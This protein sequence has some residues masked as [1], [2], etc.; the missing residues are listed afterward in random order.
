MRFALLLTTALAAILSG[1]AV[2][3]PAAAQTSRLGIVPND[4]PDPLGNSAPEARIVGGQA[5]KAGD[6]PWQVFFT[7]ATAEGRAMCGGSLISPTW[8]LTA[9]HCV[10]GKKDG[11]GI[12]VLSGTS[13][14]GAGDGMK[15][16]V[17]RVIAH[18][19]YK[20]VSTGNDIALLELETPAKAQTVRLAKGT[21]AAELERSGGVATVTGWGTTSEGG[22]VSEKLMEVQV[23]LVD[24]AACRQN[25]QQ[26]MKKELAI[27]AQQLCAGYDQGGKDS[28]QGDSG[29]P[30]VVP[31]GRGGWAQVGVVSWGAGCARQKLYGIYTRVS[32]YT[33]WIAAKTGIDIPATPAATPAA[34]AATAAAT[35]PTPPAQPPAVQPASAPA[36]STQTAST[37]A[38]AAPAPAAPVSAPTGPDRAL[39]IGIDQYKNPKANLQGSVTD[40]QNM[41]AFLERHWGYPRSAIKTLTDAQATRENILAAMDDWLVKGSKPGGRV[42]LYYSGHGYYQP[43]QDGD[44]G[45]GSDEALVPHDA[46]VTDGSRNPV[47][48]S[49]LILDDEIAR[50]LKRAADRQ[51]QVV[52]DSCHSGTA[53][54]SFD[55]AETEAI[56]SLALRV[57]GDA[58]AAPSDTRAFSPSPGGASPTLERA[59]GHVGFVPND[60]G[61]V[62]WSAV[63]ATQQALVD[64]ELREPQ[65]VFTGRFVRGVAQKAADRDGDGRVTYA[66]LLDF[67]HQESD[68]YCK[69]RGKACPNGLTP[70]L[71]ASAGTL[72]TDVL[73]GQK[74]AATTQ[75]VAETSLGHANTAG[76]RLDVL[77]GN[78][79]R[80]GQPVKFRVSSERAGHLV[81]IDVNAAGQ[82]TQ[83]FPNRRSDA[84]GKGDRIG[85]GETIAIPDASYGFE[86]RAQEPAGRGK[87]FAVVSEEKLRTDAITSMNRDLELV[88]NA[89]SYLV[90]LGQLLRQTLQDGNGARAGTWSMTQTDYEILR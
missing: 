35:T 65:G 31:D 70:Q 2:S 85:A 12:D 60:G 48:V 49:N 30:L 7:V 87:L 77:P 39:L 6:W 67:L 42:F 63:S 18:E 73:T 23:P 34:T 9:A 68:A 36:V 37:P 57:E 51:V 59:A 21:A 52:F 24:V 86:F 29:G 71:E 17:K 72:L 46:M 62:F 32:A 33:D 89:D 90:K 27:G 47:T 69:R 82:V 41:A 1:S 25:Y 22:K 19:G 4:M 15:H 55:L 10:P 58:P 5:A 11:N 3:G 38:P 76:V 54:R 56:K 79:V 74:V 78:R 61:A 83:L 64:Q 26:A 14:I 16:R 45:D 53:T 44:E 84:A 50:I 28:C 81:V 40:V 8:V 66:E 43:D 13:T 88:S 75:Q 20:G 80:L